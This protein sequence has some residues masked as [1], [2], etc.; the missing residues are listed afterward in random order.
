M[1]KEGDMNKWW[2]KEDN[3][4][5]GSRCRP[6]SPGWGESSGERREEKKKEQTERLGAGDSGGGRAVVANNNNNNKRPQN[7]SCQG[8][9][10]TY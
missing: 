3:Y 9:P 10:L 7:Q 1:K 6:V 8:P 2:R 4:L 5:R